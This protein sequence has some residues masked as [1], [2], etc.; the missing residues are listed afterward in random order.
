MVSIDINGEAKR[1]AVEIDD[2][3]RSRQPKLTGEFSSIKSFKKEALQI[4]Q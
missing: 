4:I 2:H 1:F 3:L